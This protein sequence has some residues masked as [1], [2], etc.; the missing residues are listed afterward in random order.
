ML[1]P[2]FVTFLSLLQ[3]LLHNRRTVNPLAYAFTG[4]NPVLPTTL[5]FN[6][7]YFSMLKIMSGFRDLGLRA[8]QQFA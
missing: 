6:S 5:F 2:F 7:L 1:L 3:F 4:S 8:A